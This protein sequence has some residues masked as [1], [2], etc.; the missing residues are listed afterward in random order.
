MP[1]ELVYGQINN[2]FLKKPMRTKAG[3]ERLDPIPDPDNVEPRKQLGQQI[4]DR[5]RGRKTRNRR[6][7]TPCVVKTRL[8]SIFEQVSWAMWIPARTCN[9]AAR[10]WVDTP[11]QETS[12]LPPKNYTGVYSRFSFTKRP[13]QQQ[14]EDGSLFRGFIFH[15][16]ML[17]CIWSPRH[18]LAWYYL[19]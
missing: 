19:Y 10:C 9:S 6:C 16:S 3:L 11:R 8:W 13:L 5:A 12:A 17:L 4:C 2:F 18:H 15:I 14:K 7:Q 1:A